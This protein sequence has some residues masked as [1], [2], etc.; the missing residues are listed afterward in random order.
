METTT[1]P[2]MWWLITIVTLC[3]LWLVIAP[4]RAVEMAVALLVLLMKELQLVNVSAILLLDILNSS[5]T[6]PTHQ[7]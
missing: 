1:M 2:L 5:P 7:P 6:P 3:F 4:G